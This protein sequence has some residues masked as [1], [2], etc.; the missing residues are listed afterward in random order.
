[1]IWLFQVLFGLKDFICAQSF[2]F[3]IYEHYE[4][5]KAL[6]NVNIYIKKTFYEGAT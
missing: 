2:L 5:S 4:I 1:M 3:C 6:M